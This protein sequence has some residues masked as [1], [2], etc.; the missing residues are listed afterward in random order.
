MERKIL[1]LDMDAFYASVEQLDNPAYRGKPVI[2]GGDP[3][4]RGVVSTCSYEAREFG[5]HSAMPLQEA[6]RKCPQGI[7]LPVRAKR[8]AEVSRQIMNILAEYS[9]LVEPLSL[10]E[11][12][13]DLTGSEGI[14]GPAVEIGKTIVRRIEKEIGLTAS[15]GIAPNKFLAK[16]GSD[17]RKPKGFVVISPE[18]VLEVLEDLPVGKLWGVGKRTEAILFQMGIRTIGM[19]RRYPLEKLIERL[20]EVGAHLHQLAHGRDD[21]PVV[22]DEAA[23]SI[24]HEMTFQEDTDDREFLTGVLLCLADQ[25]ARR[26]RQHQLKGRVIA[27]KIRDHAFKTI[28][29]Q[30]TL[31]QPTDFEETIYQVA[32]NLAMQAQWG[33]GKVRLL[34]ITV[35]GF[36]ASQTQLALFEELES[37]TMVQ[38]DKLHR[39]VDQ[40]KN[41]FGEQA[42]TK[43]TII[44]MN[45]LMKD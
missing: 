11:A 42:I 1:H 29:R 26:L 20:G 22:T 10:D 19:L 17:L 13:L 36:E 35:S 45:Q 37:P 40:L 3:S 24:G 8:Y 25:V 18:N 14:F 5:V 23:K 39:T 9:P 2:V 30:I 43:G 41:R 7:F 21:R 28:T 4:K 6:F 38:L 27:V 33:D 34:G 12:F 16:L 15:V 44:R 31:E 32:L